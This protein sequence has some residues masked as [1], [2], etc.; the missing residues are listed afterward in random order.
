MLPTRPSTT[1]YR[2]KWSGSYSGA[3]SGTFSLTRQQSGEDLSGTIMVSGFNDV[4]TSIHG[5]VQGASIRFGTV[6]SESI[7]YSGSVSGNSMSRTWKMQAGGRSLGGGSWKAS[8][9]S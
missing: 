6:G 2:G 3:F 4:P 1:L 8:R 9:S 5:T 7:T